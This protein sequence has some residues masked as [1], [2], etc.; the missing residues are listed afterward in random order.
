MTDIELEIQ[1]KLVVCFE[2]LKGKIKTLNSEVNALGWG[3]RNALISHV[4]SDYTM[5]E[6]LNA[7]RKAWEN[8]S[9]ER[10]V[11]EWLYNFMVKHRDEWGYFENPASMIDEVY[12]LYQASIKKEMFEIT[13]ILKTW[14][15]SVDPTGRK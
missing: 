11:H 12:G 6:E 5:H 13:S 14:I 2:E 4:Y 7:A 1:K 15:E 3:Q 10:N 8:K 9:T